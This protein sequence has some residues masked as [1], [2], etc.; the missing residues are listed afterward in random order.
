LTN[1]LFLQK[2]TVPPEFKRRDLIDYKEH[3]LS[4]RKEQAIYRMDAPNLHVMS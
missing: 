2:E 3:S 4:F 1:G